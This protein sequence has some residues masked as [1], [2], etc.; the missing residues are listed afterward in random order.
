MESNTKLRITLT[1]NERRS[2]DAAEAEFLT[3]DEM[4]TIKRAIESHGYRVIPFEVSDPPSVFVDKLI[5][6]R[7]ELIFNISEGMQGAGREAQFAAIFQKLNIPY[8]GGQAS[9][10]Y[11][12]LD[13]RLTESMLEKVGVRVPKGCL[14]TP[15]HRELRE[16]MPFPVLVKPN[17]EGSS[18]GIGE[19]SVIDRREDAGE[20]INRLLEQFPQGLNVEQLVI[21]REFTVPLLELFPGRFLEIVE[22]KFKTDGKY[23]IF[24]FDQKL[25]G[26]GK[27]DQ[28]DHVCPAELTA[29]ERC[30]ILAMASRVDKLLTCRDMGRIDIRLDEGANPYF[31]EINTIPRLLGD[32]SLAAAAQARGVAYEDI[33][34]L[35]IRS[36]MKRYGIVPRTHTVSAAAVKQNE[37][38]V[39]A[40]E[41]GV[42]VGRFPT[43]LFNAITDVE[44]ISVGHV[45]HVQDEV[46]VPGSKKEKT[47]VRTGITAVCPR[48]KTLFNKHMAAGA[49][50]L[51]GIGEMAGI[52]QAQ[53]WGWIET[54]ILLTNT[55]SVGRVHD[56]IIQHLV[57]TYP[58]LGRKVEVTIPLVGE[59]NDAFLNDVRIY[60]NT[61]DDAMEAIKT[62]KGGPVPQGS[63]GGGAGMIT[64]DFA[65]GIGS[66]SR[67]IRTAPKEENS[68][69]VGVLVQSNFGNMRN[70]TIEGRVVGRE[71]DS[72]YPYENR[73]KNPYGSVIVIV[74]TDAPL[75]TAQLNRLAKRAALGLGRVGSHAASTSGEIVIAFS[76]G[77]QLSRREKTQSRRL[78]LTCLNDKFINPLYEAVIEATEEAILNAM[79]YSPG[80]NGR[81]GRFSPPIPVEK[82]RKILGVEGE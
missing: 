56:G 51:N 48:P 76:T 77:N 21:G 39:S 35:I 40:R 70:L 34:G 27:T 79:W 52:T 53:E 8:T 26:S 2:D 72:L 60:R 19:D 32:G 29:D 13:K 49:F 66:S 45:T 81:K 6:T 28:V 38:R 23:N 36:A 63:V 57:R 17:Y 25:S 55:M 14:I 31:L 68:Y 54:P 73:R 62:A 1:Y 11:V 65:G 3:R 33:F 43:G 69:T 15:G 18:K 59:T 75:L 47:C 67:I 46:P 41:S 30:D 24:N 22:H 20:V 37:P 58:E 44:G 64:F 82:V 50:V 10:L 7:P 16:D 12:C 71:L 80:Q 42:K 9:L 74:A 61:P 78:R 4:E 5:E